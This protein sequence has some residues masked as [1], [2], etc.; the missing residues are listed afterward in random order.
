VSGD[1]DRTHAAPEPP[2]QLDLAIPVDEALAALAAAADIWGADWE[3]SGRG[4]RLALPV[5]AGIRQGLVE[6]S[7]AAE[8]LG[9]G[10]RLRFDVERAVYRIHFAALMVLLVGAAGALLTVMAP[11][12]PPLLE[13]LP[14]A[15]LLMLLSWFLVLARIRN[16]NSVDFLELI[17][18]V[19]EEGVEDGA[20]DLEDSGDAAAGDRADAGRGL[21]GPPRRP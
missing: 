17:A 4:G 19:A 1:D 9:D 6:G 21:R 10:T 13:L 7:V 15:G 5:T 3:R 14:V 12:A 8:R 2:R 18:K 11:L 20:E 16:R